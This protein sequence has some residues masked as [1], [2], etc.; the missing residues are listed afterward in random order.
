MMTWVRIVE[1][2]SAYLQAIGKKLVELDTARDGNPAMESIYA[3]FWQAYNVG[4]S[5]LQKF[6]QD[7][8]N[9]QKAINTGQLETDQYMFM[10]ESNIMQDRWAGGLHVLG[11]LICMFRPSDAFKLELRKQ[12]QAIID[13]LYGMLTNQQEKTES[14]LNDMAF[15]AELICTFEEKVGIDTTSWLQALMHPATL[16]A[17]ALTGV[18]SYIVGTRYGGEITPFLTRDEIGSVAPMLPAAS[19]AE[20][21]VVEV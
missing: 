3:S 11:C 2:E 17:L 14:V 4:V 18:G 9:V 21:E 1:E 15:L 8:M 5:H 7:L 16:A 6:E 20:E 13:A 10:R 12:Q 19:I